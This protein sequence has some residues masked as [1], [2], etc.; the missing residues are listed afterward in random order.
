MESGQKFY[1]SVAHPWPFSNNDS[2]G[3]IGTLLR[4]IISFPS[5]SSTALSVTSGSP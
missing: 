2:H 5:S 1:I 3:N 4:Q